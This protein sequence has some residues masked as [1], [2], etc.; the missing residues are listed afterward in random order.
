MIQIKDQLVSLEVLQ[1]GFVCNIGKCKGACCVE[2][3]SCAPLEEDEAQL[4]EEELETIKPFLSAKGLGAISNQGPHMIDRDG[5]QVTPLID[6]KEC[7]YT[8]FTKSGTAQCGIELAW[9]QGQTTF[10]KPISCHLYP[11]RTKRYST[12]EAVNY[13][14]WQ[15]CSDAC[16][17]GEE[18]KVPVFK[19]LK[20]PLIRKYGEEW[21]EA[22]EAANL[23][24]KKMEQKN[25]L[26][27]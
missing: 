20:E 4:L 15:I 21:F 12:F 13:E 18:L 10:R 24:L 17:L 25:D 2:G 6:G 8:V 19:F 3:D 11:I 7:A 27:K 16:A 9:N 23:E 22:L 5:D 26:T 1:N 14:R